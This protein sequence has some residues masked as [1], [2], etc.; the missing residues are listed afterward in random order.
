MTRLTLETI[1]AIVCSLFL[2]PRPFLFGYSATAGR[3]ILLPFPLFHVPHSAPILM[4][5]SLL[6]FR[7]RTLDHTWHRTSTCAR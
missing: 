5:V 4:L 2:S 1:K 6:S 7:R 3:S